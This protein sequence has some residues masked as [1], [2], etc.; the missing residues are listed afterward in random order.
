MLFLQ[1]SEEQKKALAAVEDIDYPRFLGRAGLRLATFTEI[2]FH[3]TTILIRDFDVD[4]S[5]RVS[6]YLLKLMA[7]SKLNYKDVLMIRMKE[8]IVFIQNHALNIFQRY[9]SH[10]K[11]AFCDEEVD[12]SNPYCP[13]VSN[14]LFEQQLKAKQ[15]DLNV[16]K[17]GHLQMG[18]NIV[19]FIASKELDEN[20]TAH[21][22]REEAIQHGDIHLI[23]QV[24]TKI[25][26]E[27]Y[28]RIVCLSE[29]MRFVLAVCQMTQIPERPI[30]IDFHQLVYRFCHNLNLPSVFAERVQA[31]IVHVK[32]NIDL[33][34]QSVVRFGRF[35]SSI[36]LNSSG[37][38]SLF[39]IHKGFECDKEKKWTTHDAGECNV[40]QSVIPTP[41]VKAIA[42]IL[43]ALKL[44]FGLDDRREYD[45]T[46]PSFS[47]EACQM[48]EVF[49]FSLWLHQ[50]RMRMD[51][52]RGR[53]LKNVLEK[54]TRIT[55][56]C[57][58]ERELR[59]FR[60][61][62]KSGDNRKVFQYLGNPA[63]PLNVAFKDC[64]PNYIVKE[65]KEFAFYT[66]F[67]DDIE[68]RP[69]EQLHK[70]ALLAPLRYQAIANQKLREEI[71]AE[72][73][74]DIVSEELSAIDRYDANVFL[75]SFTTSSMNY[76]PA[77]ECTNHH[78]QRKMKEG[79]YPRPL[80][81][82]Y[83][84]KWQKPGSTKYEPLIYSKELRRFD[85]LEFEFETAFALASL[86]CW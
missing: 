32:P 21:T 5:V 70:E 83:L 19:S 39:S 37:T 78:S 69:A 26:A 7:I 71:M 54:K 53:A 74:G 36:L 59:R 76:K 42:L 8:M 66:T 48:D 45:M 25:S 38:G 41:E 56:S 75:K 43:F 57:D 24:K 79:G 73:T 31:L 51:V 2:L 65:S 67:A 11:V 62:T 47:G 1:P 64:V 29:A 55:V 49:D 60:W 6:L 28:H 81:S 72:Q 15:K 33:S 77:E 63:A 17:E 68:P 80:Y 82:K 22:S 61:T 52:W 27:A 13:H 9:L 84:L 34:E 20:L 23:E 58:R 30:S 12:E 10:M 18:E 14:E 16:Q 46:S 85:D 44:M 4:R 35:N 50:L 3:F 40:Y 86:K